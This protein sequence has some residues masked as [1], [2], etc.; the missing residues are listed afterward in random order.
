[1]SRPVRP[2]PR[3]VVAVV[4]LALVAMA[5]DSEDSSVPE[6]VVVPGN[7]PWT[8]TGIDVSIDDTVSIEA[9]GEITPAMSSP[10]PNG[11]DGSPESGRLQDNV[12]GLGEANHAGLIGRIGEAGAP[13]EV[14]STLLSTVDLEGR[15]FL[16]IN[17][18]DVGDNVGGFTADV[19]VTP[20]VPDPASLAVDR[21]F[22][23]FNAQD[24]E[25]LADVFG[26]D[27]VFTTSW[28]DVLVGPDA[29]SLFQDRFGDSDER[30]TDPFHEA[31][32]HTSFLVEFTRREGNK[33]LYVL[34]VETDGDRLVGIVS[35]RQT[36]FEI[37]AT[38]A[39][40]NLH[41]AFNVQDLDVLA[42]GFEDMAYRSPDGVDLVGAEAAGSWTDSFRFVV[43]RTTGVFDVGDRTAVFIAEHSE[44]GGISTAYVVEVEI[45]SDG[46]ITSMTERR[47]EI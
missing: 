9:D 11:P 4:A 14:G 1:M 47:L 34:D 40:D 45:S 30:L 21:L 7:E 2:R 5:C 41:R 46:R 35:R 37:V 43:T 13:F 20:W 8:D 6:T 29:V 18:G 17:D 38:S 42:E 16:G 23:V 33:L 15:L 27:V 19:S 3:S 44:P 25:G 24:A 36:I 39:V 32:G 26:D 12:D 28:G 10:S 31:D 22:E